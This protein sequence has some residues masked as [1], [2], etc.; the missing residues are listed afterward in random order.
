MSGL[1]YAIGDVHGRADLLDALLDR[2]EAH[3]E[4][5]PRQLVFLGDYVDRGP[6]SAGVVRRLRA[7]RAA[8][9]DAVVCLMG[10]HEDMMLRAGRDGESLRHWRANGGD[11]TLASYGVDRVEAVPADDLTWIAGLPTL[12]RDARRYFVHAGLDPGLPA[13]AASPRTRL[14]VRELFLETEH[15]FGRHVVH[16]HTPR[17]DFQPDLRRYRTNLDTGAVYGGALTAGAFTPGADGP[18]DILQVRA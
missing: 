15:D 9:P 8:E 1:T 4:G 16:G 14:W 7:L 6:D 13:E 3:R 11:E 2:I 12:H 10:N 18:V 5:R 17:R